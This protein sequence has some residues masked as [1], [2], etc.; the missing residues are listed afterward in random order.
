MDAGDAMLAVL[1]EKVRRIEE[2]SQSWVT[3]DE[4]T[5]IQRLAYGMVATILVGVL[6]VMLATVIRGR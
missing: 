6:V 5:P 1:A 3:R 2:R 4:Y